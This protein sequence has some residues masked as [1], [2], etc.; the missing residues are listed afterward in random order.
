MP[1]TVIAGYLAK[2]YL[3][4]EHLGRDKYQ[5]SNS[6]YLQ[7]LPFQL[8]KNEQDHV[9]WWS[10][11]DIEELLKGSLAYKDTVGLRAEV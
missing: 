3:K 7:T 6:P 1:A 2:E 10:E 11:R 4:L 8:G 5:G 9:I